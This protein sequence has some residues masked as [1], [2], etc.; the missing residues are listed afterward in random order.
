MIGLQW[1]ALYVQTGVQTARPA[2]DVSDGGW[3]NEVGSAT[4]LFESINESAA[5]DADYIESGATPV[6]DAAELELDALETAGSGTW[7]VRYRAKK[8]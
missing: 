8:V 1:S 3:L 7:T 2:A 5:S 6:N 4:N